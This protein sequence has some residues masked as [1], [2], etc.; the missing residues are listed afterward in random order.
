MTRYRIYLLGING[1]LLDSIEMN[2]D[3]DASALDQMGLY[4]GQ[5]STL[6]LWNGRHLICRS[7]AKKATAEQQ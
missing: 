7:P 1:A 5:A 3:G 6:E 4:V 2:C